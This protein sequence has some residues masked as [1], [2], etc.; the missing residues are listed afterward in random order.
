MGDIWQWNMSVECS[1]LAFS[2]FHNQKGN[3]TSVV[4]LNT[5]GEGLHCSILWSCHPL[6]DGV[7]LHFY[8]SES[9][10]DQL[11]KTVE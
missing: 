8:W 10:P 2:Q 5:C 6:R 7:S 11:I 3:D 4:F 1:G 9:K